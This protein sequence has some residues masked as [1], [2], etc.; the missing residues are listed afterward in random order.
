MHPLCCF[1]S[2]HKVNTDGR[3]NQATMGVYAFR[4]TAPSLNTHGSMCVYQFYP[5]KPGD[6]F[7]FQLG[8]NGG[9]F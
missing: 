5:E 2:H 8:E 4:A 9:T 7:Q 3:E 1:I 6:I